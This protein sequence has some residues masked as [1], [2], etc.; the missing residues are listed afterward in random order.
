MGIDWLLLN[1]NA[2]KRWIADA[3]NSFDTLKYFEL[4]RDV[5]RTL[6]EIYDEH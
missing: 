3:K 5:N 1:C 2:K 4:S 6:M